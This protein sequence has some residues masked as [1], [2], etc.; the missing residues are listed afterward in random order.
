M[1]RSTSE[2][3]SR[4][5]AGVGLK[6]TPPITDP[7]P[8]T[9]NW[10]IPAIQHINWKAP[11][12]TEVGG[13]LE[14]PPDYKKG[15]KLP[16]V[17]GLHGGPTTSTKAE[18]SYDPHNGRLYFA[19]HGYA[20]FF[21]NYRGSTGYGDKFVTDLIGNENDIEVKD[22]LAGIQHLIKEG[23]ADENEAEKLARGFSN[24][25]IAEDLKISPKTL[26]IHR[27]KVKQKLE[28]ETPAGVAMHFFAIRLAELK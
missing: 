20:A 15:D 11:D 9:A 21:P 8:H 18:L 27:A 5:V 25:K 19:A 12:G 24:A 13:I 7:N 17:V 26:D 3:F 1:V 4:I 6:R 16:L 10:R 23:I 22:I 28:V 14:L 2:E